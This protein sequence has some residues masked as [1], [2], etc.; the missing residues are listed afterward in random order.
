[1]VCVANRVPF[2]VLAMNFFINVKIVRCPR[3]RY[4]AVSIGLMLPRLHS[5][6]CVEEF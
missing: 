2:L 1:M 4:I 5:H 6:V 3:L